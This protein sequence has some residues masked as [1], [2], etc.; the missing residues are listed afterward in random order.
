MRGISGREGD[1]ATGKSGMIMGIFIR[2]EWVN[3][4][5]EGRGKLLEANGVYY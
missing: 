5:K 4:V 3:G 1:M 2:G